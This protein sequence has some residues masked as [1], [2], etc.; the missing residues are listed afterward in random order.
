[1]NELRSHKLIDIELSESNQRPELDRRNTWISAG[2]MIADPAFGDAE[3]RCHFP[4]G[5]EALAE[6][7]RVCLFV[8]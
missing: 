3:P 8:M 1:M 7:E 2:R 5:Q 4:R 6:I